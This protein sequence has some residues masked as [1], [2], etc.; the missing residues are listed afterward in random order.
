MLKFD[1]IPDEMRGIGQGKKYLIK[2]YGCQMNVHDSETIAGILELMGYRPD[3]GGRRGG[4]YPDQY[5][6]HSGKRGRQGVWGDWTAEDV[7]D[8]KAGAGVG[9]V[10]VHVPRGVC[11]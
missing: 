7:E 2:T 10:R 11:C 5:L 4:G 9:N 8:G 1:Q 3:G 6:C